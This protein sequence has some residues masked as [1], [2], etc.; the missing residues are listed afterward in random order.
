MVK[1]GSVWEKWSRRTASTCLLLAAWL[2]TGALAQLDAPGALGLHRGCGEC[3]VSGDRTAADAE[4]CARELAREEALR[5]AGVAVRV[6]ANRTLV[7]ASSGEAAF[8]VF[9]DLTRSELQGGIVDERVLDVRRSTDAH[10]DFLVTVC[11]EAQVVEYASRPDPAFQFEV[12]GLLPVYRDSARFEFSV[13][14]ATGH[15]QFF[16]V[17]GEAAYRIHPSAA[18]PAAELLAGRVHPFPIPAYQQQYKL[19]RDGVDL[20]RH[21]VLLFT[22]SALPPLSVTTARALEQAIAAIEPR[23]RFLVTRPLTLVE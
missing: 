22:R 18:E 16:L 23:D 11:L 19:F 4:A 6:E 21:F 8:E 14:G 2:G 5:A 17:E 12:E 10:G 3:S 7:S 1:C 13:T 20:P 15:L 9:H